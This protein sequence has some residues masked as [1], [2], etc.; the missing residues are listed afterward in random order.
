MEV[1]IDDLLE[2]EALELNK[3]EDLKRETLHVSE[4]KKSK[5]RSTKLADR[6]LHGKFHDYKSMD[7]RDIMGIF[8]SYKEADNNIRNRL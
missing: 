1:L 6:S 4:I 8:E 5:S 2:E 3:I 7:L